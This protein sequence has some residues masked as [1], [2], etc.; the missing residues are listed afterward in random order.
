ML[1]VV[2]EQDGGD[3]GGGD[4]EKVSDIPGS[5]N[6]VTEDVLGLGENFRKVIAAVVGEGRETSGKAEGD[7]VVDSNDIATL[8]VE[9]GFGRWR[10][11]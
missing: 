8:S 3:F 7:K 2:G 5:R 10:E 6:G 4:V 1:G 11:K 9:G